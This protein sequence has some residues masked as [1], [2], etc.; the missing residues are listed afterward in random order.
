MSSRHMEIMPLHHASPPGTQRCCWKPWVLPTSVAVLLAICFS[1]VVL[2]VPS[3][4]I[5][6]E[7]HC[8]AKFGPL[9]SKWNM[10]SL[11]PRCVRQKAD[12]KLEILQDGLY[13][14]YGQV[15]PNI[16][17]KEKAPFVVWLRKNKG[18]LQ[19]LKNITEIQNVGGT[20]ELHAGD[21]IDLIFNDDYQVLKNNTFWGI[22]LLANPQFIF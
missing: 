12:W 4:K 20:Y 11:E 7:Q 2:T 21:V 8:V 6:S 15:A 10:T 13:S 22:L 3:L 1:I 16:T 14:I 9:P 17:Y 5:I 19:A 18:I